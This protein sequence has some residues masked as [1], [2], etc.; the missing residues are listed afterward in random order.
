M[1]YNNR[2]GGNSPDHRGL[3]VSIF[4]KGITP[5]S[6]VEVGDLFVQ[7]PT[8]GD[9]GVKRCVD[10]DVIE[11]VA[12]AGGVVDPERA[13][14]AFVVGTKSRIHQM[15][16]TGTA[17]ALGSSIVAG[18]AKLVKA[19]ATPNATKVLKVDTVNSIVEVLI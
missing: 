19:T 9:Y 18:G 4:V 16:Y 12:K 14:G 13:V 17:P 2:I 8:H 6:P 10:G 7:D 11:F 15:K 5:A 1:G 3:S